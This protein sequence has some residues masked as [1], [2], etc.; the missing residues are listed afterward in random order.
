MTVEQ[1]AVYNLSAAIEALGDTR[2]SFHQFRP[3]WGYP[4]QVGVHVR[5]GALARVLPALARS[6][7][8]QGHLFH[9][10]VRSVENDELFLT[11]ESTEET[12]AVPEQANA[13]AL[14][15]RQQSVVAPKT[16][17]ERAVAFLRKRGEH[18]HER[19]YHRAEAVWDA[20][21]LIE[22]GAHLTETE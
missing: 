9:L 4:I 14:L 22:Q 16:D 12:H 7:A 19:N 18:D 8:S 5:A 11:V 13:L 17:V 6:L 15:I 1:I 2:A 3:R 20:A 21:Y 10:R